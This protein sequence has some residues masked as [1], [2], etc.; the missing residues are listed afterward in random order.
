MLALRHCLSF[1]L[2]VLVF[3]AAPSRGEAACMIGEIA[4][5]PVTVTGLTPLIPVKFNGSDA[6]LVVD[7]GA[8]YSV[9][10]PASAAKL[11]LK[12]DSARVMFPVVGLKPSSGSV[13]FR[14]VG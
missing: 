4:E 5:F 13:K 10:S 12:L 3:T 1:V 11:K 14:I 6:L 8:F 9:L 7:S 2:T